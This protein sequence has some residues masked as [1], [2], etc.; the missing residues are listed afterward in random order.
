MTMVLILAVTTG[1]VLAAADPTADANKADYDA[2][3]R[4]LDTQMRNAVNTPVDFCDPVALEAYGHPINAI[5][6][7]K[8]NLK[9]EREKM[10]PTIK[11]NVQAVVQTMADEGLLNDPPQIVEDYTAAM[12]RG[13]KTAA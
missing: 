5:L 6:F 7:Q 12:K 11:Q 1:Q 9:R 10:H 2:R 8:F 3:M 13:D 4:D